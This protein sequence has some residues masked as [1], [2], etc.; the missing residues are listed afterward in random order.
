MASLADAIDDSDLDEDLELAAAIRMSMSLNDTIPTVDQTDDDLLLQEALLTSMGLGDSTSKVRPASPSVCTQ[1]VSSEED[2]QIEL[3]KEIEDAKRQASDSAKKRRKSAKKLAKRN[4]N[5]T[6]TQTRSTSIKSMSVDELR[7]ELRRLFVPSPWPKD[8]EG[9]S[10]LLCSI[11]NN[12][13]KQD[14]APSPIRPKNKRRNGKKGAGRGQVASP[15][16]TYSP[17][18]SAPSAKKTM[19][20]MNSEDLIMKQVLAQS[21]K[22][23]GGGVGGSGGS[24]SNSSSNNT[25]SLS[26]DVTRH[27]HYSLAM[28]EQ[29]T[30]ERAMKNEQE[31]YERITLF[32]SLDENIRLEAEKQWKI[33]IHNHE[34]IGG[35]KPT[36]DFI[37][38]LAMDI[39]ARKKR[40]KE[41][42]LQLI[43]EAKLKKRNNETREE[44]AARFAKAYEKRQNKMKENTNTKPTPGK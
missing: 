22:E 40:E 2:S 8:Q 38:S 14:E 1:L 16:S 31:D 41:K 35:N 26:S 20:E 4:K 19:E 10:S 36:T 5:L 7:S 6:T 18:Y 32:S 13:S 43:E 25:R 34:T 24:T 28:E 44:R 42:E 17:S 11:V 9:L 12:R 33:H 27:L 37:V 23:C 39:V 15:S 30:L 21:L 3:M 29:K